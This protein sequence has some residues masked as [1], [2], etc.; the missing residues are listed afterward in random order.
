MKLDGQTYIA[1]SRQ[2]VWEALN[3]PEILRQCIPGCEELSPAEN[4]APVARVTNKIGPITARFKALIHLSELDA[5]N[6][7]VLNGEGNGGPAGMVK[8]HARV[9]L[10]DEAGGTLLTYQSEA[11]VGGK[12]AQIGSRL[13]DGVARKTADEFFAKFAK[14]VTGEE[15]R[16]ALHG[17]EPATIEATSD[18]AAGRSVRKAVPP[19]SFQTPSPAVSVDVASS[20]RSMRRWLLTLSVLLFAI[21][22]LLVHAILWRS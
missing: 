18:A 15:A 7:Y 1:S 22:S 19:T 17:G 20:L 6:S 11:Q 10:T 14:I 21:L 13:I 5:P 4:D 8:G 16:A 2:R 9:Q 3:D 12:L